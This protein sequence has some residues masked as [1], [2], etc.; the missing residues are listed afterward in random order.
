M[1]RDAES[2]VSCLVIWRRS[3]GDAD[4]RGEGSVIDTPAEK[5]DA[6]AGQSWLCRAVTFAEKVRCFLQRDNGDIDVSGA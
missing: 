5:V 3:I 6:H 4:R 1:K 2:M